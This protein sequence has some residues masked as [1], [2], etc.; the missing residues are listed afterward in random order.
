MRAALII[1]LSILAAA[2]TS[3][4]MNMSQQET[5]AAENVLDST[6]SADAELVA[7]RADIAALRAELDAERARPTKVAGG[8]NRQ[9]VIDVAAAVRAVLAEE[10]LLGE[11]AAAARAQAAAE[12][13]AE[14]VTVEDLLAMLQAEGLDDKDWGEIWSKARAAGLSDELIALFE[15][16]AE[17]NPGDADAQAEVGFAYLAKID[18]VTDGPAK[19]MWGMKADE[20]F[21]R[22]LEINPDHWD[23]RFTKAIS[24]SF[25]PPIFGKQAEAIENF[26]ILVE[27]QA[28]LP[29]SPDHAQTY[30]LL[31]NLYQQTGDNDRAAAMWASGAAMFP[32]N[33]EL[34]ARI[35]QSSGN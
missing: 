14:D 30:L 7:L 21:D 9:E 1:A 6:D 33:A 32:D 34:A 24:L 26:E 35:G 25:W 15:K 12:G 3:L 29:K 13:S 11:G 23:A 2:G 22:A 10:G 4:L 18:E 8:T 17:E 27:R 20:A 19:G 28:N 16:R 5:A 31:G